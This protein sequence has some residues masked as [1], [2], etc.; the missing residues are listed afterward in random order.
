M[1][2]LD[3]RQNF[4]RAQISISRADFGK[5]FRWLKSAAAA[6]ADVVAAEESALR[7]GKNFQHLLHGALRPDGFS[8]C[9]HN[10][11]SSKKF[12]DVADDF[13]EAVDLRRG[14]INVETG[15]RRRF[16]AK[17][18]HERLIAVMPAA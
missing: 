15:P 9:G 10:K 3:V 8:G 14:V 7:P 2:G 13:D 6:P 12:L 1:A 16:H 18:F 5:R 11:L 17:L 4:I